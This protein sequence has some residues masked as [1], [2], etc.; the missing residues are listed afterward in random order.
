MNAFLSTLTIPMAAAALSAGT[1]TTAEKSG[2]C[3]ESK[4]C[5]YS[6]NAAQVSYEGGCGASADAMKIV[7]V[8]KTGAEGKSCE[9][10]CGGSMVDAANL[11]VKSVAN[12]SEEGKSCC[13]SKANS[14]V[15]T[16]TDGTGT[17]ELQIVQVSL[18]SKGDGEQATT[19]ATEKSGPYSLEDTV[20]PFSALHAQSGAEKSIT[21][22]AGS[23]ATVI[24]FWNQNCPYVEG[25]NG[26]SKAVEAFFNGY[27]D[28]GVQVVAIDAGADKTVDKIK[29]YAA[30]KPFPILINQ[31]S[32]LAA[33]FNAQ[34]TPHAFI[35]DKNMKL[36]YQGAFWTGSAE[37][38]E[39]HVEKA[40]N[41]ILAGNEP[42][43]SSTRGVGCSIKWAGG[44]KPTI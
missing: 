24:I 21:D 17:E 27:K 19:V 32:T 25:P 1:V 23:Q 4:G 18:D 10:S 11:K 6:K 9:T 22:I 8:S 37:A 33:K 35:L 20:S 36:V 30:N 40:V 38:R 43:T 41:D 14:V 15:N 31:D 39:L 44:K 16:T 29:E 34:Y 12:S 3:S 26:A 42:T 5:P 7:N 28:K 13:P 2:S